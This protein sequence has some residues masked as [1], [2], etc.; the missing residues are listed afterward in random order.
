[1]ARMATTATGRSNG[2]NGTV[3]AVSDTG[4][5]GPGKDWAEKEKG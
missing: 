4:Y 5:R 2:G 3:G 1:M